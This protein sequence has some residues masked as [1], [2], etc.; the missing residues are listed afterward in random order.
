MKKSET[1]KRTSISWKR[2]L[3]VIWLTEL[4]AIVG[5]TIVIPLLPLYIR[6][7]GVQGER[8]VRMWA[9][10]I[11]S[12]HAV[13]M[14]VFG[15]IW[16]VLG[17][18]RGRKLMVERAMFGGAFVI[19]LMG[20]AQSV[21]QLTL[22]RAV[23]GALT[24]T[25]TAANALVATTA[26]RERTG[27]ALGA[28]QMAIYAGAS[29]GP[30]IGGVIADAWGFRATFWVTSVLLFVAALGVTFFVQEAFE[31]RKSMGMSETAED[32]G[33]WFRRVWR[34]LSPV[35][36]SSPLLVVMGLHL[37]MRLGVRLLGPILP[38]FVESVASPGA[39]VA[40]ISGLIS[41]VNAA[42]AALGA[43]VLGRLSDRVGYR[44]IL[45]GS[46]I[47]SLVCYAPQYFVNSPLGLIPLQAG[48]GLAMGGC[49]AA[50]NASLARLS[51]QGQEGMVYGV[52]ASVVSLANAVGPMAGSMLAAWM[53]LR[54]PFLVAAGTFGVAGVITAWLMPARIS[55]V[56]A[57]FVG[58]VQRDE[59]Q[60]HRDESA[61]VE[62]DEPP[63]GSPER[64]V[65]RG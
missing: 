8:E 57:P 21:Q 37:A 36:G 46:A 44:R 55:A 33:Y 1:G 19:A 61:R 54:A 9:G 49:L 24:G 47:A 20:L 48:A 31:Q 43:L 51:P 4:I 42:G 14:T 23:Q 11:F 53:S 59:G 63:G 18:Q 65:A 62:C 56:D 45:V 5:F 29:V 34:Y 10:A 22:L 27:Y 64:C 3:V 35:L 12:A 2:N 7:L 13:T 50:L 38:L 41:G 30:L 52:D 26:P 40:S 32:G 28:L 25:V 58:H 17:D 6:E 16:G 15:P 39:R 60:E